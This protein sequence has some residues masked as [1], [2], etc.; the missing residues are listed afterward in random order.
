MLAPLVASREAA[1]LLGISQK[2]ARS[3]T[4]R[5]ALP[6]ILMPSGRYRFDPSDIEA[7]VRRHRVEPRPLTGAEVADLMPSGK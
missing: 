2:T 7:F 3:L 4:R 5:G 6:A 1:R